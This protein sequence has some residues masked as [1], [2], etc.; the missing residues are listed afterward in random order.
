MTTTAKSLSQ[1]INTLFQLASYGETEA[2][3][4]LEYAS[5]AA[6][7]PDDLVS[8]VRDSKTFWEAS[9]MS[10]DDGVVVR[11]EDGS[12]FQITIVQSR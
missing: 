11:F 6:E 8:P 2:T 7:L 4:A 9:L 12:E 5:Q 3:E 10:S 1:T